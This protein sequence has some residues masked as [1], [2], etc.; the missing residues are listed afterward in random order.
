MLNK[1]WIIKPIED[2]Y[3]K[4]THFCRY[5]QEFQ[6]HETTYRYLRKLNAT[7]GYFSWQNIW[8]YRRIFVSLHY[9]NNI[10]YI[11][12]YGAGAGI[13]SRH[14]SPCSME[15]AQVSP[16]RYP[17]SLSPRSPLSSQLPPSRS[18]R[19]LHRP[20]PPVAPTSQGARH[21]VKFAQ[22]R[23]PFCPRRTRWWGENFKLQTSFD[24]FCM[25]RQKV[26]N[27]LYIY[28]N[29]YNYYNKYIIIKHKNLILYPHY[30]PSSMQKKLKWSLKF[31]VFRSEHTNDILPCS[32]YHFY[33]FYID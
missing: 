21:G 11:W 15:E 29:N 12:S 27:E 26:V 6:C 2:L 10:S 18:Q 24:I 9:G 17:F 31:E 30:H 22:A 25:D 20:R 1:K 23:L 4:D 13:F 33:R 5:L 28:Y 14:H 32:L 16:C 8:L 19:H 7:Y 3:C